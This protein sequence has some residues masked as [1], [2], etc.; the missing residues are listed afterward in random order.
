M[1][2]HFHNF[3]TPISEFKLPSKFTFPFYYEPHPLC[4][5]AAQE[6]Q[7]YLKLQTDFDHNFGLNSSKKDLAFG[8]MFGVLVVQ[9]QEKEVGYLSAV[10]GSLAKKNIHRKFVPPVYDILAKDSYYLKE[11]SVLNN[12]NT[13]IENLET[14]SEYLV[15]CAEAEAEIKKSILDIQQKLE[16]VKAF[17]KDRHLR[18][19]KAKSE[20]SKEAYENFEKALG[21]ESLE[22]KHFINN[23]KRYWQHILRP[24]N[25]KVS[26]FTAQIEQLKEKRKIKSA[27]LQAY[28]SMQ[29]NFLNSK[30]EIKNLL[31]LFEETSIEQIPAGSGE[32]AAPKLLQ[33]AYLHDLKPIAM[34]EFWW[35]KSPKKEIRK[36]KQFYPA[37]QGRCK[38]ILKHMLVGL[39]VDP[40][41]FLINPA[42]KK[43]LEI[44]FE[45]EDLIVLCKPPELL[46]VPGIHIKDSVYTRIKKEVKDITGPIIVH[47]LDMATSG[48]LVLAKNKKAHKHLQN[49]FITKT[50]KKRYTAILDGLLLDERGSISLPLR[51]DLEDRPRQLVC[52]EHGKSAQT[53]WEII[54]RKDGKTKIHFYPI[55]GRTHQLRV[56]ASHALGLNIPI[57]GDDLYGKKA[58]RLY[59]HADSLSLLHPVHQQEMSFRKPAGFDWPK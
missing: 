2:K 46:S 36:H 58:D 5:I 37:C 27:E 22:A 20:L 13:E 43:E 3:L 16:S 26:E 31:D 50:I 1:P 53:N 23:V 10:S 57:V 49:Q 40:N 14:N 7:S 59:L 24:F 8:K 11:N 19:I 15:L 52:H 9:N 17:K 34:A 29:Y 45:D 41:P 4:R 25:E 38:P 42:I 33:Y 44:I 18:R 6:I 39:E 47:R 21:K 56:H 55:T 51:V 48:L 30:K 28:I 35:G 32:C 12:I 54:K